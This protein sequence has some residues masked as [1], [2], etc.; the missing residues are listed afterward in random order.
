MKK[1]NKKTILI[2]F[3]VFFLLSL[4]LNVNAVSPISPD[5]FDSNDREQREAV[6]NYLIEQENID[7]PED[8]RLLNA[9][10]SRKL[11]VEVDL[12]KGEGISLAKD[13]ESLFLVSSDG[14]KHDIS[15][16]KEKIPDLKRIESRD[17]G[18][19]VFISENSTIHLKDTTL[20][21]WENFNFNSGSIGLDGSNGITCNEKSCQ[22]SIRG[23]DVDLNQ[24]GLFR[25]L[26]NNRFSVIDGT[27]K[28]QGDLLAGS[29]EFSTNQLRDRIDF[30]KKINL[31]T[32]VEEDKHLLSGSSI[33][34]NND[35]FRKVEIATASPLKKTISNVIVCFE[36]R[37]FIKHVEQ[38]DGYI[39]IDDVREGGIFN[40]EIKG[41]ISTKFEDDVHHVGFDKNLLLTYDNS[42][43]DEGVFR[44]KSCEGCEDNKPIGLQILNGNPFQIRN[45]FDDGKRSFGIRQLNPPFPIIK[46]YSRN[47]YII[48]ETT[49]TANMYLIKNEGPIIMERIDQGVL[50]EYISYN[51]LINTRESK[52]NNF[53]NGLS[54]SECEIFREFADNMKKGL[55]GVTPCPQGIGTP[56]LGE[57]GRCI[58]IKNSEIIDLI[59]H[60][61][62]NKEEITSLASLNYDIT[63][64]ERNK[65]FKEILISLLPQTAE[66]V[67]LNVGTGGL[68]ELTMGVVALTRARG[69]LQ[70]ARVSANLGLRTTTEALFG[71]SIPQTAP[72]K[73]GGGLKK[74]LNQER[75]LKILNR[76]DP[77]LD[78]I[79]LEVREGI[80]VYWGQIGRTY[81][82]ELGFSLDSLIS[83]RAPGGGSLSNEVRIFSDKGGRPVM[84]AKVFEGP[85][86]GFHE[87]RQLGEINLIE[88]DLVPQVIDVIHVPSIRIIT[89]E[90]SNT[91]IGIMLVTEV[92]PG[93]TL[94]IGIKKAAKLSGEKRTQVITILERQAYGAGDALERLHGALPSRELSKIDRIEIGEAAMEIRRRIQVLD[95]SPEVKELYTS[96]LRDLTRKVIESDNLVARGHGDAHLGNIIID[97]KGTGRIID[98]ET[99][100]RVSNR[101]TD[102]VRYMDAIESEGIKQGLN[103]IEIARLKDAVYEGYLRRY[104]QAGVSDNDLNNIV[105]FAEVESALIR[106]QFSRTS[107]SATEARS[108][109]N[110]IL[111]GARFEEA[112]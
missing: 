69:V 77:N 72:L 16:V 99:S 76:R 84:V 18:T 37:D 35:R 104:S 53:C 46:E 108:I 52:I 49:E 105:R 87:A 102:L 40:A 20:D 64:Y 25:D 22:F 56:I 7:N 70:V 65:V 85:T 36:C 33:Q 103:E 47:F 30:D 97:G 109:L 82:R 67:V 111:G 43:Q 2:I 3:G 14:Q 95:L 61:K 39:D 60:G 106:L 29:Y 26:G 112:S 5:E 21:Q 17:D 9:L 41:K 27:V 42:N 66:D 74:V 79:D 34:V 96:N 38:Y 89:G 94:D 58:S 110:R 55:D 91:G 28:I 12:S 51:N 6:E 4:F 8:R 11:I 48:D 90:G 19:I 78:L 59:D 100:E 1:L 45:E 31:M 107:Q 75:S 73:I 101:G 13:G 68:G 83:T 57:K 50:D 44:L 80:D 98:L 71:L 24:N 62:I 10:L 15:S 54:S 63:S 23:M 93:R 86:I 81:E 88:K 32:F 92:V